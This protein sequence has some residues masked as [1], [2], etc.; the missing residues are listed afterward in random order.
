MQVDILA[1]ALAREGLAAVVQGDQVLQ[2]GDDVV[3][4]QG[5]VVDLV[6]QAKL[7]V[8]LVAADAGQVVALGV[9]V[10]GVEQVAS[11]LRGGGVG[12]A[13]LAVQIGQGL[14][15]RLDGLL[16]Q[17]VE[18][19]RVAFE[20]IADLGLGHADGHQEDDRGLLA[21]AVDTPKISLPVARSRLRSK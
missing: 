12:R 15:L 9:E 13:D 21:L 7:A 6:L 3:A 16:L 5:A 2:G 1:V 14:V 19:E 11:G 4:A 17:R 20:R 8:D 10:E 18:H